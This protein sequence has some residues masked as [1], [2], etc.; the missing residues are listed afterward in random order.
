MKLG[1]VVPE[2]PSQ[3]HSF[4]WREVNALRQ[5][6]TDVFLVSTRRPPAQACAHDFT[7]TALRETHY[8]FPP[9]WART[10][11]A[12]LLR[13]LGVARAVSYLLRLREAPWYRRLR[14]LGML[15]CA[16]DLLSYAARRRLSHIHVHSCADAAHLVAMC[17]LLGGPTYSLTLHGDLSVYGV[18][19]AQKAAGASFV[20]CVARPLLAQLKTV[21]GLD[22][23]RTPVIW[24]GVDTERFRLVDR[25]KSG[26][27]RLNVLTIARLNPAKGH[28]YA[29]AAVRRVRDAGIEAT[30]TI[31]G[32]GPARSEIEAEIRRLRIEAHVHMVGTISESAVLCLLHDCDAFVLSSVGEGEASPVSVM[33]AMACGVPVICSAIGGTRD[34]ITDGKDGFLVAQKDDDA[35]ARILIRLA[36][37]PDLGRRI[38]EAARTR[39]VATF[40]SRHSAQQLLNEILATNAKA[41][42]RPS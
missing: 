11:P 36:K 30:Y 10:L 40:S 25:S 17:R 32:E 35:I 28:Q 39:A 15:A 14:L 26:A 19:H 37:D 18:D 13:P 21:A 20:A 12:L 3:T 41:I 4:F 7:Q 8:V 27:S 1:Y 16:G 2:F 22:V 5:L 34:M 23:K 42:A 31:A 33:E 29:L 38:G 9:H 6:G 24:M